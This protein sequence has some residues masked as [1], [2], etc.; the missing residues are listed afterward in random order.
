MVAEPHVLPLAR[1]G[2]LLEARALG[3]APAAAVG[4]VA[5]LAARPRAALVVPAAQV[6]GARVLGLHGPGAV[7]VVA[8]GRQAVLEVEGAAG[9]K[10][11]LHRGVPAG[12]VV[13][14]GGAHVSCKWLLAREEVLEQEEELVLVVLMVGVHGWFVCGPFYGE[15]LR[16][17]VR[18]LVVRGCVVDCWCSNGVGFVAVFLSTS[19]GQRWINVDNQPKYQLTCKLG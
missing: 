15:K 10:V 4:P 16:G 2:V 7:L 12:V 3:D 6:E 8:G 11:P 19:G 13:R 18:G 9:T 5:A 1:D 17:S 14:V